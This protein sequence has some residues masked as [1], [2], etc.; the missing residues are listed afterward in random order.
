MKFSKQCN[1]SVK[2]STKICGFKCIKFLSSGR[3]K[4]RSIPVPGLGWYSPHQ[5]GCR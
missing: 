3:F 4:L 2:I 5:T 1:V